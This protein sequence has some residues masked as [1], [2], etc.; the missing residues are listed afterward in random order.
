[1]YFLPFTL[2][3]YIFLYLQVNTIGFTLGDKADGPFQLEI[4]YIGVC[5]DY[6]HTEEF[7]YEAY[8]KNPEVWEQLLQYCRWALNE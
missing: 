3:F 2:Y 7:A 6:A 4:D 5:K 8:K 1:M